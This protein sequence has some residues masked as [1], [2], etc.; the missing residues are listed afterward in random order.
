VHRGGLGRS[1]RKE[2]GDEDGT[3]KNR[4]DREIPPLWKAAEPASE[5]KRRENQQDDGGEPD[6]SVE[7]AVPGGG[8]L[9][10]GVAVGGSAV[11]SKH[12]VGEAGDGRECGQPD[13]G[14]ASPA[15]GHERWAESP[16]GEP[17]EGSP[18]ERS[19]DEQ[20]SWVRRGEGSHITDVVTQ[21]PVPLPLKELGDDPGDGEQGLPG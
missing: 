17:D 8:G 18:R 4:G 9:R 20:Y 7:L 13:P 6:R 5:D 2:A 10:L 1:D 3:N 11:R 15:S 12:R 21:R 16:Q 14:A 19:R